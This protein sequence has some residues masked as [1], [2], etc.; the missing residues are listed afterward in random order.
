[1]ATKAELKAVVEEVIDARIPAIAGR[2]NKVLGDYNAE[3]EPAG[4]NAE[5]PL[6]GATYIRQIHAMAGKLTKADGA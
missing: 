1:M 6:R 4:P 3:G 2:V 5:A